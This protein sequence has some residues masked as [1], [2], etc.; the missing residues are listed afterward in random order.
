[1]PRRPPIRL[2]AA[3]YAL[4]AVALAQTA[5]ETVRF[6]VDTTAVVDGRTL[7]DHDVMVDGEG[8]LDLGAIADA[9]DVTGVHLEA[10]GDVLLTFDTA[11]ELR[12]LLAM[13]ADVVRYDG[14]NFTLEFD[15]VAAGV[16]DGVHIDAVTRD[17]FDAL[18]VSFDQTVDLD[19]T[20]LAADDLVRIVPLGAGG[21]GEGEGEPFPG[22]EGEGEP[23]PGGGGDFA[24]EVVFEGAAAGVDPGLDVD[25]A[26]YLVGNDHLLLS[27]DGSGAVD[28]VAFDDE[29]VLEYDPVA[30]TWVLALDGS[31][32]SAALVPVDLD[33]FHATPAL[34]D[35]DRDGLSDADEAI[36][37]TDPD[38]PDTDGDGLTD[39]AEVHTHGTDPTDADTDGDGLSDGDEVLRHGSDPRSGDSDGDGLGDFEEVTVHGTDPTRA[40]TDGDGLSDPDEINVH[41]TDPTRADTDGDGLDDRDELNRGTDPTDADT[42]GDGRADGAEIAAGTDPLDPDTDDDGLSDG[43]EIA[44]NTDPHD[45]D[46]DDDGLLDGAEVNEHG[47]DPRDRDTDRDG[48]DD[49]AEVQAAGTD[50]LDPD[51]DDDGLTDGAEVN[52][53]GTDPLSDDSDGDGRRDFEELAAGSDPNVPATPIEG[54]LFSP[55]ITVALGGLVVADEDVV[56]GDAEWARLSLGA[57]PSRADLVAFHQA[58]G[59]RFYFVLDTAATVGGVAAGPRD[60]VLYDGVGYS[61]AFGGGAAGVP[62][63]VAIDALTFEGGELVVSFDG[64][65]D[66]GGLLVEDVDLVDV[67]GAPRMVVVG[68]AVG[69]PA[70]LDVDGAHLLESGHALLSFDGSG[71]LGNIAF[72]DEDVLEL[73][74]AGPSWELAWRGAAAHSAW[75]AADLDA[76][77]VVPDDADS[78]GD[79]LLDWEEVLLGTDPDFADS[80]GDGV[81]DA[82]EVR[83]HGT[84]PTSA[85]SDLD[86][87]GDGAELGL[88]TDPLDA[89]SDADGLTDG[90]EV[91]VTGTD[92]LDADTDDDGLTDG[93]EVAREGTDPLDADTDDDGLDDGEE[94]R[95][96]GTDPSDADTDDDGLDDGHELTVSLTDPTDADTDDDGL[97]DGAE[98]NVHRTDPRDADSDDDGLNDGVE[99]NG[100]GTDPLDGDSD[101]DGLTDGDEV[102]VYGTDPLDADTDGDGRPDALEI[103]RGSNPLVGFTVLEELLYSADTSAVFGGVGAD[104][105]GVLSES[106]AG[107]AL[108]DVGGLPAAGDL[109]ALHDAGGGG[110]YFVLDTAVVL[111]GGV[112]AGPRVVVHYDGAVFA[113]A[114]DAG[115]AGVPD[116]VAI[117]A[118]T[119]AADG[120][121]LL[122]FDGAVTVGGVHAADEDLVRHDEAGGL[123]LFLDGSAAGVAEALDL[124][125][126]HR[127]E[128][129]ELLLSFDGSGTLGVVRFDDEDVLEH[130]PGAG[131]WERSYDGAAIHP[132]WAAADLDALSV[133]DD[134]S[135]GDGTADGDDNC[136]ETPNGDQADEDRDGFGDACDGCPADPDKTA[137]G[138]CGCGVGDDDSDGDG[139][140][141]CVDGCPADA[142]KTDAGVCGCGVGDDDSDGDGTADCDDGCPADGDKV[143][144]G[145]GGCGAP[146]ADGD[147]D[148]LADCVDPCVDDPDNDGDGDGVCGDVDNCPD[149]ANADQA[150][151]DGDGTGDVCDACPDDNLDDEDGD[152]LCANIDPCPVDLEN[153]EDGDGVCEHDD[154]CRAIYNPTQTDHDD[155]GEGDVCEG[156]LCEIARRACNRQHR[157]DARSCSLERNICRREC[158]RRDHECRRACGDDRVACE[159]AADA[160]L[161][162]CLDE[163]ADCVPRRQCV[164]AARADFRHCR[165]GAQNGYRS[166]RQSCI[167]AGRPAG[168]VAE[169]RAIWRNDR[170]ECRAAKRRVIEQSCREPFDQAR[171]CRATKNAC[172]Q[173]AIDEHRVCVAGCAPRD[174]ECR[175]ACRTERARDR[176][177]CLE[178]ESACLG[179]I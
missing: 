2:L 50:P 52:E 93:E 20:V 110:V 58:P 26:H 40:D 70:G 130:A 4:P 163:G 179:G 161:G 77:S 166:C 16:P 54:W 37:G 45:P 94:V 11:L 67:T 14:A 147:G 6:S 99:V 36:Y 32:L 47:T 86:G 51:S 68:G 78:D 156:A 124:D 79:G 104:D 177:S 25:A 121:W 24:F 82:D 29:D 13:P 60:V 63:G 91:N 172:V 46:T 176:V 108:R 18:L 33:A 138:A 69:V 129:G 61:I 41:G 12:A 57:L 27:F 137:N 154:N 23:F 39:G 38:D 155:D 125:G 31:G 90:Q 152:G 159:T 72:A 157:A 175:A 89:D 73:D 43:D 145:G 76:I 85:D 117:D 139:T 80:D 17:D 97:G 151:G 118:L 106:G 48:L 103:S 65:V 150:D 22:G 1:M 149:Q 64:T 178:E 111:A 9:A 158:P 92:P 122:S 162:I 169:C 146:D 131:T 144:P 87:L 170:G 49:A 120:D 153:D 81:D 168:C 30:D 173:S 34:P 96:H 132:A 42:D 19:G 164:E 95:I 88:G 160:Q 143:E 115:A 123:S 140:A 119:R 44:N 127:L 171:E 134:D 165:A 113:E 98:L 135:D 107:M 167:D 136:P 7:D 105:E 174:R 84:D 142:A 8:P 102:L 128:G 5:L 75:G 148:G 10:G 15:S 112:A 133:P 116:G 35:A 21:E 71:V 66:L 62:D 3:L 59:G 53:Y 83:V 74:P 55:D 109:V 56:S 141:D 101:D 126:A 114:F 100:H 28:G